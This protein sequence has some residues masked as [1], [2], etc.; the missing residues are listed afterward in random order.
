VDAVLGRCSEQQLRMRKSR[1]W[2]EFPPD[3]LP[4]F[5]AEMDFDRGGPADGGRRGPARK[6]P[7]EGN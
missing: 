6:S 1:K 4:A 5:I 3:V 2:R 7:A